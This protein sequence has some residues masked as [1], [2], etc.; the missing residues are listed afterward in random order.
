M[1]PASRRLVVVGAG[2]RMGRA[3]VRL[4]PEYGLALVH[5]VSADDQGKDAGELAG[6][7]RSGVIVQGSPASLAD[8]GADVVIEFASPAATVETCAAAASAG[9]AIVSGTTGLGD[10]ARVALDRAAGRV[11]VLW[12]P[13]MSVGVH[14]LGRLVAEAARLL[15]PEVAVEITETHHDRKA[16]SPSG[17]A[18]RLA[19]AV[20]GARAGAFLVHGRS[21][22]VGARQPGELGM[23]AIRGGDVVGDHT[24]MF[25]A[26]GE[27]IELSHRASSR[28]LF[29]RGALAAAAWISGKPAGR[30][31][32]ADVLAGRAGSV[33]APPSASPR[34]S[35]HGSEGPR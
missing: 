4:A 15:G 5:A 28:D 20:Q 17:T 18:L 26:Q 25:L 32:L 16:D 10:D 23:H 21:G 8:V 13:N 35:R 11:P 22:A 1:S 29:A 2:G 12:E 33:A 3:V 31:G 6:A 14:V 30:Y 34:A 24:V 19:E 27:R 9:L 7:G